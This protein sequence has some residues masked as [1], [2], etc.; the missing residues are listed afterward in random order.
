MSYFEKLKRHERLMTTM[1]DRNG[2]DLS[3]AEQVGLVAPEEVFAAAQSC[4]G[5]G[6]VVACESHLSTG[7]AG[8]PN[9]CRNTE[10]IRRIADDMDDL[11]FNDT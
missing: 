8:L 11:G 7:D 5:C 6:S 4:M 10:M 1:A 3:L 9:Y 2:A